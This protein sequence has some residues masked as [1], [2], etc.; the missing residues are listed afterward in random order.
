MSNIFVH[1]H[2]GK[3]LVVLINCLIKKSSEYFLFLQNGLTIT[4]AVVAAIQTVVIGYGLQKFYQT[5]SRSWAAVKVIFNLLKSK[6][7][8]KGKGEEDKEK[9]KAVQMKMRKSSLKRFGKNTIINF[10]AKTCN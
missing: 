3:W 1:S 9:G 4:L 5:W 10:V 2:S 7:G 6:I 8:K